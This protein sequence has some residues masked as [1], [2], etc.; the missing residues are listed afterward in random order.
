MDLVK[1]SCGSCT[2][3]FQTHAGDFKS[4]LVQLINFNPVL[5]LSELV[6]I[7]SP[8][9][10]PRPY[11][12]KWPCIIEHHWRTRRDAVPFCWDKMGVVSSTLVVAMSSYAKKLETDKTY[13]NFHLF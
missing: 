1:S 5:G 2:R 3:A 12:C 13:N 9:E 4:T 11:I 7:G 8:S 10:P 6:S